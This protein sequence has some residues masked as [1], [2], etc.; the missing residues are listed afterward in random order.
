MSESKIEVIDATGDDIRQQIRDGVDRAIDESLPLFTPLTRE[1][2]AVTAL[3]FDTARVD[4]ESVWILR[5]YHE[6]NGQLVPAPRRGR[7][8]SE[9]A[10]I[11]RRRPGP[12]SRPARRGG[13]MT[14]LEE[15][16]AME[17]TLFANQEKIRAC[18]A[19]RK[20]FETEFVGLIVRCLAGEEG[21]VMTWCLEIL[22]LA[23]AIPEA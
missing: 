22:A 9:L 8:G 6:K 20:K 21:A 7:S 11:L 23:G 17:P 15:F 12:A 14:P 3:D 19:A 2:G 10:R 4:V 16:R 5:E 13:P 1:D 18:P